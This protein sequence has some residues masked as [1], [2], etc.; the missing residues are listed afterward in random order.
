MICGGEEGRSEGQG[1]VEGEIEGEVELFC[2]RTQT[3]RDG[4]HGA[5]SLQR[6]TRGSECDCH[7]SVTKMQRAEGV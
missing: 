4:R 3:G 7:K 2:S 5:V 1:G 6:V